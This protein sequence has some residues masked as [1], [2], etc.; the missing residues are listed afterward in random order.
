MTCITVQL[1]TALQTHVHPEAVRKVRESGQEV[2]SHM[3]PETLNTLSR[4]RR[5]S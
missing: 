5:K 2:R 4:F 3:H 1:N